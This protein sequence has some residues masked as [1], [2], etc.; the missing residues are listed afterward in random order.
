MYLDELSV[1]TVGRNGGCPGALLSSSCEIAE[2]LVRGF[3]EPSLSE[4]RMVSSSQESVDEPESSLGANQV[5]AVSF[6][7]PLAPANHPLHSR[8]CLKRT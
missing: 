8:P 7:E 5:A 1:V 2:A 4:K 6:F 3:M